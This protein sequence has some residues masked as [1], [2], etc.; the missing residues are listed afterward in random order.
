MAL[1]AFIKIEVVK[2]MTLQINTPDLVH[3]TMKAREWAHQQLSLHY[4]YELMT[5]AQIRMVEHK[6]GEDLFPLEGA[7]SD[8]K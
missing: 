1:Q 5:G 8:E 3:D 4:A 6:V 7:K 2:V